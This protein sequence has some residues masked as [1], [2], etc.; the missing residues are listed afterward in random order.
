MSA[1][2][3]VEAYTQRRKESV[4]KLLA[5]DNGAIILGILQTQL[6][7]HERVLPSSIFHD[8]VT[9][10]LQELR[11]RGFDLPQTSQLYIS[12]WLVSGYLERTFPK[13]AAEEVYELSAST[14]QA[15]QFAES[16]GQKHRAATQSRL[17][18]VIQQL[19][20]LAEQTDADPQIRIARLQNERARIDAEIRGI[21]N[22]Q[23]HVLSQELA[24]EQ[25]REI[26]VLAQELINDFRYVRDNFQQLN[27]ELRE[28]VVKGEG[29]RGEILTQLFSGVDV[30]SESESGRSFAAFWRLLTDPEQSMLLDE[31][32]EQVLSRPF[33][34]LMERHDQKFLRRLISTLLEQG[35]AVHEIWQ[36]FAKSLKNFVQSRFYREQRRLTQLLRDAQQDAL[37]LKL[38]VHPTDIIVEE[39][40]LTS[41]RVRSVAQL[42]LYDP[43]L[44]Y[45]AG[46]MANAE[47]AEISLALI[48]E[49]VAQSEINFRV[50]K[51]HIDAVLSKRPQTT[52]A[53][54]L[55]EFP[56]E[57]GLG[58]IVGYMALGSRYGVISEECETVS[59]LGVDGV[60]RRAAIPRIYFIEENRHEFSR[61]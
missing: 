9:R 55:G 41:S 13:G 56:A 18:L 42:S 27:R 59:W 11:S 45:A 32:T 31:A 34:R 40:Y 60:S 30:I 58:S 24:L 7:D 12:E 44:R 8:R 57:Q 23:I 6:F 3:K 19:V 46:E 54:I 33:A 5:A 39:F 47:T 20:Q 51:N 61:S 53:E 35:G 26:I 43:S 48:G 21:H 16:L 1:V 52:I 25:I 2:S 28:Q 49:M 17:S 37:S 10:E 22:G 36:F 50:L 29:S 38:T 14:I 4:W 15:I